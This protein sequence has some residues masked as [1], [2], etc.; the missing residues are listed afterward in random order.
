MDPKDFDGLARRW[1][2][3]WDEHI[4]AVKIYFASRPGDLLVLD[5]ERGSKR[6]A[7]E[8]NAFFRPYFGNGF[9]EATPRLPHLGRRGE[10]PRT[11]IATMRR[12]CAAMGPP[13]TAD[14]RRGRYGARR[15]A[16]LALPNTRHQTL[17]IS[18]RMELRRLGIGYRNYTRLACVPIEPLALG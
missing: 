16:G 10:T 1:E 14:R 4:E 6:A 15:G 18:R 17:Q 7:E 11:N 2:R 9:G 3:E 13:S 8:L 5:L 12:Q